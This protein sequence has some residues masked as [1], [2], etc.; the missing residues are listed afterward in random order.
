MPPQD[1]DQPGYLLLDFGQPY[2]ARSA[3]FGVVSDTATALSLEASR[4]NF[5]A[6]PH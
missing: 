6:V 5:T 1:A 3:A 2:T 4:T